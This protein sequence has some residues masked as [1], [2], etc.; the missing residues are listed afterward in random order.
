MYLG[1]AWYGFAPLL[2]CYKNVTFKYPIPVNTSLYLLCD[3]KNVF[4]LAAIPA[5]LPGSTIK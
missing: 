3:S 2:T 1:G 5:S 4:A